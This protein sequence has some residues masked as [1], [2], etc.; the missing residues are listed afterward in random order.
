MLAEFIQAQ[1]T[2]SEVSLLQFH[3]SKNYNEDLEP[4]NINEIENLI[5]T[6]AF[7]FGFSNGIYN[8]AS[9]I[10]ENLNSDHTR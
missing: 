1:Q 2:D 7:L 10:F 5:R 4:L 8:S 9:R 3:L 6:R